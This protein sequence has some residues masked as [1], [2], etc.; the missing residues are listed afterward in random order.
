MYEQRTV[1]VLD[2]Q[3]KVRIINQC[4][5]VLDW[6]FHLPEIVPRKVVAIPTMVSIPAHISQS[7][8]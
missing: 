4:N 1:Q 3:S 6:H 8:L 2:K 7:T 5:R